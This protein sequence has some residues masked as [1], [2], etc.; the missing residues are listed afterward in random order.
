ML[1][2]RSIPS[3]AV[4][5]GDAYALWRAVDQELCA[6]NLRLQGPL[7]DD[8]LCQVASERLSSELILPGL[9]GRNRARVIAESLA[10]V[11][12]AI[13]ITSAHL[14]SY[15]PPPKRQNV[16]LVDPA[17]VVLRFE[18]RDWRSLV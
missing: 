1:A 18:S 12:A 8:R 7:D 5:L 14:R 16:V 13:R 6:G 3:N 10:R 2:F 17:F 9:D 15:L 11:I 4:L